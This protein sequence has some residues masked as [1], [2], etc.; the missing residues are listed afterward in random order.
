TASYMAPEQAGGKGQ[1]VGPAAD[2]YAL[3]AILYETLTGR[4][5]FLGATRDLTILQVLQEEPVP[6]TQ[7]Q[8]DVPQ[9][10]EA[11]CLKCLE[12]EA[13]RRYESALALAEDLRCFREGEPVSAQPPGEWEWPARWARRV[14]YEILEVVGGGYFFDIVY[15]ARQLR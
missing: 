9:D 2:V 3:G 8:A 12:K 13:G 11:I 4:P 6:P 15:K 14:G 10:R 1:E 7:V 5:P